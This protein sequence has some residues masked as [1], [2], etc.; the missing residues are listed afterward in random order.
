MAGAAL[1]APIVQ[2]FAQSPPP[3]PTTPVAPADASK[4]PGLASGPF[5]ERSPFERPAL[6]PLGVVSGST[7]TPLQHLS[8]TI[9]P[10]DLHFQRH[11]NGIAII[12]PATY[13]LT[14]H[15]LCNRPLRFSLDELKRFPSETHMYF[16]ECAG[17]GRSAYRTPKPGM[18]PQDV[19]GMTSNA[20]WTGVR[21]STLLGE[22]GVRA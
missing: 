7:N 16:V 21:V 2:L 6:S 17:N 5:S 12:D 15:G 11:H 3:V 1:S 20:E 22:V 18:T 10:S 8:G 4:V 9:T 13:A 14:L 19:D